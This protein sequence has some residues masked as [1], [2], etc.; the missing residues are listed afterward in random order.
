MED[1]SNTVLYQHAWMLMTLFA[2]VVLAISIVI[3]ESVIGA[4]LFALL[5]L[6]ALGFEFIHGEEAFSED[7]ISLHNEAAGKTLALF[8]LIAVAA[9]PALAAVQ[10]LDVYRVPSLV[11]G[12]LF[13][14]ALMFAVYGVI[15]LYDAADR[16]NA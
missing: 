7:D 16:M 8:G 9:F 10:M 13:L 5:I 2:G 12:V 3:G 15:A 1:D 14:F 11:N 6:A 4:W